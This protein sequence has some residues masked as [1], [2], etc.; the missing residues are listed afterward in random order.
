MVTRGWTLQEL[1][2]PSEI[3]FFSRD[4]VEIGKKSTLCGILSK[5]TRID[6][7]ILMHVK[8]L[9]SASIA[10]RMSWAAHRKTTR[11]E[12]IAYCLMGIFSVN[13]PMLYGE[14]GERA[15][16]RLQEE[17]MKHSDDQ[18]I[19]AW[20][21]REAPSDSLHGL[22]A[23]SPSKFAGCHTIFPYDNWD[24]RPPYSMT[25][26]GLRIDLQSP[27]TEKIYSWRLLTVLHHQSTTIAVF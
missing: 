23:T 24:P 18:S 26:R 7:K 11:S 3:V 19:F 5:I 17:I 1:L 12:D 2:A 10:K 27:N 6:E 21:D 15:F 14:G 13:M 9:E 4:W 16:L 22:L 20:V 25:N 8:P